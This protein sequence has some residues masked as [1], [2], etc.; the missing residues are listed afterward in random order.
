MRADITHLQVLQ[1]YR[2]ILPNGSR[3][4]HR[5]S[6]VYE[7]EQ[8]RQKTVEYRTKY[9]LKFGC[10][11]RYRRF[12]GFLGQS[13]FSFESLLGASVAE[14]PGHGTILPGETSIALTNLRCPDG[15]SMKCAVPSDPCRSVW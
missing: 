13:A 9:G 14:L 12:M 6:I 15:A 7:F 1:P 4:L 11:D 3:K 8:Y 10:T 5:A 2:F